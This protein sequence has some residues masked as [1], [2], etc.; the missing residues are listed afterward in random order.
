M[1]TVLSHHGCRSLLT[2]VG[3]RAAMEPNEGD[4]HSG[5]IRSHSCL[6][7]QQPRYAQL[8]SP[9]PHINCLSCGRYGGEEVGSP[10]TNQGF[11]DSSKDSLGP[12]ILP[13]LTQENKSQPVKVASGTQLE[14]AKV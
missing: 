10:A 7:V 1:I 9:Q 2:P 8:G 14:M 11:L 13:H 12:P 3:R 4:S 6:L 5:F